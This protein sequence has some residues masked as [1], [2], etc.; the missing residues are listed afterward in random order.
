MGI[1]IGGI[2]TVIAIH[3]AA[4][5]QIGYLRKGVRPGER[6]IG[7]IG[8]F[9]PDKSCGVVRDRAIIIVG[10]SWV[11][12]RYAFL[13]FAILSRAGTGYGIA[14]GVLT[15]ILSGFGN[16]RGIGGNIACTGL[17]APGTAL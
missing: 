12:V 7:A 5:V 16:R 9:E 6:R 11:G 4:A 1:A 8:V 15:G 14:R 13:Q 3:F 17:Q 2:A 10:K